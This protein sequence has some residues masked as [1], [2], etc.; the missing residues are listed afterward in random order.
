MW[1]ISNLQSTIHPPSPAELP[2]K[3]LFFEDDLTITT[4]TVTNETGSFP[5]NFVKSLSRGFFTH[6]KI[7]LRET[8]ELTPF[9]EAKQF[10]LLGL[11]L[12]PN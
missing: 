3:K 5:D 8:L 11:S 10:V 6:L 12:F 4:V 7:V 2:E 1:T 9:E